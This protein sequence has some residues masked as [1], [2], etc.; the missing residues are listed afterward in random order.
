[1]GVRHG[2]RLEEFRTKVQQGLSHSLCAGAL[3]LS[4]LVDVEENRAESW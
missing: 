4:R 2:S 1:M 3:L